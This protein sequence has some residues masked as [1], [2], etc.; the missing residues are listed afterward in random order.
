[1]KPNRLI[2]IK[3]CYLTILEKLKSMI[4]AWKIY[5]IGMFDAIAD[6][7]VQS[8]KFYHQWVDEVKRT[9]PED[10]LL[11]IINESAISLHFYHPRFCRFSTWR[12]VGSLCANSWIFPCPMSLF[13]TW[14][15]RP[16]CRNYSE[17]SR[18]QLMDSSLAC[19][20]WPQPWPFSHGI[21]FFSK[22]L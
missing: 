6:G 3:V 5:S 21:F 10:R 2:V 17:A 15:I 8:S 16:L 18:F 1:M 13:P 4:H 22:W 7:K 20:R 9:V 11:V 12:R 19:L 14:M